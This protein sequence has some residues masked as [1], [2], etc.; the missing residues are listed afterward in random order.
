MVIRRRPP[1]H[2]FS[3]LLVDDDPDARRIYSEYLRMKGWVVF[4]AVDGRSGIDKAIDLAPELIVLDLA[5]PRVDGWTVLKHLRGS[6]FT[7]HIPIIVLTALT[8]ARD[9]AFHA[10][11]DA[12]LTKPCVPEVLWLQLC[13]LVR[14]EADAHPRKGR[15]PATV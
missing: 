14:S 11:C 13:A 15:G 1:S 9:E 10:G 3:V 8:N 12:F 2:A 5:M 7:A 4:T 6:S